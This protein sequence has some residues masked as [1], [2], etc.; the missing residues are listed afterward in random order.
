MNSWQQWIAPIVSMGGLLLGMA[1]TYVTLRNYYDK[2]RHDDRQ[3]QHEELDRLKA[4]RQ[5]ELDTYAEGKQKAYAA[6]RDFEHLKQQYATLNQNIA[7]LMDFQ[8]TEV[9]NLESDIKE[10][11]ALQNAILVQISGSDTAMMRLLK[12]A[13]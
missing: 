3:R 12:K 9:Q 13:E 2:R 5:A 7:T 1:G 10:I 4:Q 8:R 11:K 6:Q